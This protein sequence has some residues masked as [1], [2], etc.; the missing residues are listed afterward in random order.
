MMSSG[1]VEISKLARG[2][3]VIIQTLGPG[4]FFGMMALIDPSPRS[5]TVIALEDTVVDLVDK[6]FLDRE[7]NQLTSD[8]RQ[9][10][11]TLVRRLKKTT[12]DFV[13]ASSR[14]ETKV[15][16]TVRIS[17]KSESDFF[18]A[19]IGNLAKGGLFVKTMKILPVDTFLNVEFSLPNRNQMIHTTGKVVWTR[20]KDKSSEKMPPGIGIQFVDIDPEDERLLKNYMAAF[21]SS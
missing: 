13:D 18:R 11:V 2:K 14:L 9:L 16:G 12:D 4:A 7:F 5:A 8:F 21:Q 20:S 10:L 17:F 19:Y 3:K 1:R 15:S 6:E